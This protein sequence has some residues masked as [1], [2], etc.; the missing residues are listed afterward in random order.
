MALSIRWP[1]AVCQRLTPYTNG[2]SRIR[3]SLDKYSANNA[4]DLGRH[5]LHN[6]AQPIS[7]RFWQIRSTSPAEA[8][9]IR[10]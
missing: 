6:D 7:L 5:R 8:E 2:V 10:T 3:Q 9:A 1:L 4:A